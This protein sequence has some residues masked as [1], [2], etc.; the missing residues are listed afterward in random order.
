MSSSNLHIPA[1]LI[2]QLHLNDGVILPQPV[3]GFEEGLKL[4]KKLK[5]PKPQKVKIMKNC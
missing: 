5:G 1:H 2:R 4:A 3:V